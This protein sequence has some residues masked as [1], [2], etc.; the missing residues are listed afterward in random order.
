MVCEK[1]RICVCVPREDQMLLES[2]PVT[3]TPPQKALSG[4]KQAQGS[5]VNDR[6]VCASPGHQQHG[7]EP[8]NCHIN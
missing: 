1:N 2:K 8:I 7:C 5:S 3:P 4:L 6:G